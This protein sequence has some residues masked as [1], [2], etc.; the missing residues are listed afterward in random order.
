MGMP[1]SQKLWIEKQ[2]LGL[3]ENLF[4]Y[5]LKEENEEFPTAIFA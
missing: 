4:I 1:I 2:N 3:N 5:L